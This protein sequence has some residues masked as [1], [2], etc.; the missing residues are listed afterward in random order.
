MSL[1]KI[2]ID[3]RYINN[4]YLLNIKTKNKMME[5]EGIKVVKDALMAKKEA[6]K[7]GSSSAISDNSNSDSNMMD[8]ELEETC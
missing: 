4:L 3:S 7:R 2:K 6:T 5:S 8:D 1:Y